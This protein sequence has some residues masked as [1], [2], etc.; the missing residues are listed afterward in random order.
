MFDLGARAFQAQGLPWT[1]LMFDLRGTLFPAHD[2]HCQLGPIFS[3]EFGLLF[4]RLDIADACDLL[5]ERPVRR[6]FIHQANGPAH[7]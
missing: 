6:R 5:V 4:E 2:F 7:P 3:S 1:V